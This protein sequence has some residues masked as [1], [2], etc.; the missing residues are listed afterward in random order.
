MFVEWIKT[1]RVIIVKVSLR[2]YSCLAGNA[3]KWM[4]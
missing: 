4:G 2:R 1:L 3:A